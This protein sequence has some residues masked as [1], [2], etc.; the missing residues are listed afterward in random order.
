DD[1]VKK[2]VQEGTLRM[3]ELQKGGSMRFFRPVARSSG[4]FRPGE[5]KS[6]LFEG[7]FPRTFGA[8]WSWLG[9]SGVSW[10]ID[11]GALVLQPARG[12]RGKT[13]S[14]AE[15]LLL[16]AL[17]GSRESLYSIEATLAPRPLSS[18]GQG[19]LV[20]YVDDDPQV[21][22]VTESTEGKTFI[23]LTGDRES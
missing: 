13:Q 12:E 17:P 19:G 15:A 21:R 3:V 10:S 22:V 7:D 14:R 5:L 23:R 2:I 11:G 1:N 8:E 18:P 16:Y 9:E 4:P 6:V 20:C